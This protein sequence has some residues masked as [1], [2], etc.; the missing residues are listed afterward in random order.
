MKFVVAY[1]KEKDLGNYLNALWRFQYAKYGRRDIQDQLLSRFPPE[2]RTKLTQATTREEAAE[3]VEA[4]FQELPPS[5]KAETEAKARDLEKLL[6]EQSGLIEGDLKRIYQKDFPFETVSVFLTTV[7]I[8][9][10]NYE[11]RWF[12]VGREC[13]PDEC[14]LI[15]KHE[16]NHF[17]FYNCFPDLRDSLGKDDYESLKEGMA[18]LSDPRIGRKPSIEKL[19]RHIL[20][21]SDKPADEIVKSV[22]EKRDSLLR[23]EEK[24]EP[25]AELKIS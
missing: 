24:K 21:V 12:M 18:V 17:M 22:L 1:S 2:F 14:L 15:S 23:D 8:C 19:E 4:Y 20:A 25:A 11:D 7:G 3:V 6:N 5:F 9:P 10:Y 16:L 13:S